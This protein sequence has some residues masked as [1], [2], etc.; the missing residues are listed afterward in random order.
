[1]Y[2]KEV[3]KNPSAQLKCGLL[4]ESGRIKLAY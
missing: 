2:K 3:N 1:M 4:I